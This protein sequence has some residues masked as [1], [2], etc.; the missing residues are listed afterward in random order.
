M[1]NLKACTLKVTCHWKKL[2]TQMNRIFQVHGLKK[3]ILGI[4]KHEIFERWNLYMFPDC[5]IYTECIC[6]SFYKIQSNI[7]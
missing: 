5:P 1:K 2:K 7:E 3:V 6:Q 4:I